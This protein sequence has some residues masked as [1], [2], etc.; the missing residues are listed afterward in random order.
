MEVLI[1]CQQRQVVALTELNQQGI[2]RADLD[3]PAAT[4]IA[5]V[6]GCDV[7]K[8]VGLKKGE[9]GEALHEL[10]SVPGAGKTL[11]HSRRKASD[12]TDVSTSRL[13]AGRYQILAAMAAEMSIRANL[14]PTV[15]AVNYG[16]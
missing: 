15:G 1:C 16:R 14:G 11:H 8:F 4:G 5:D 9:Y 2:N 6:G 3:T 13:T 12:Q 7:V 10:V